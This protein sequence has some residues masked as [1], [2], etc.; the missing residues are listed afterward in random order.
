MYVNDSCAVYTRHADGVYTALA[1]P[2]ASA[3][4]C[5]ARLH[6]P[7][8]CLYLLYGMLEV[9]KL[10][11]CGHVSACAYE[12]INSIRC[13]SPDASIGCSGV[14]HGQWW[15]GDVSGPGFW[16]PPH[17]RWYVCIIACV[18]MTTIVLLDN[19]QFGVV[20]VCRPATCSLLRISTYTSTCVCVVESS[21]ITRQ[22]VN[23]A[24]VN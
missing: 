18:T 19:N 21:A 8:D 16:I 15:K 4:A 10:F 22:D 5:H 1:P 17:R 20:S 2:D 3:A 13:M 14:W 11:W 12:S 7:G 9:S 6:E 23:L 24:M